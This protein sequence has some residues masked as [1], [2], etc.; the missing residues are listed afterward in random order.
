MPHSSADLRIVFLLPR[1]HLHNN[2]AVS[3]ISE[4]MFDGDKIEKP[5]ESNIIN[6]KDCVNDILEYR[7]K[8]ENDKKNVTYTFEVP[9]NA[10]SL[11]VK[12]SYYPKPLVFSHQIRLFHFLY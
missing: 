3:E 1:F 10:G 8:K 7:R 5:Y 4:K 11:T 6:K 2:R 9:E 12:F